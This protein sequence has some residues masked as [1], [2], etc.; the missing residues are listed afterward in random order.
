MTKPGAENEDLRPHLVTKTSLYNKAR[1]TLA[2]LPR[3]R[4]ASS[5]PGPLKFNGE[6]CKLVW[7]NKPPTPLC[8]LNFGI[9]NRLPSLKLSPGNVSSANRIRL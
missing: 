5:Q 6:I 7:I 3:R 9:Q 2:E 8:R 1:V 4:L